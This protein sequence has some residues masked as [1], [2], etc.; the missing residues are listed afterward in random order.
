M[1]FRHECAAKQIRTVCLSTMTEPRWLRALIWNLVCPAGPFDL[2]LVPSGTEGYA[3]LARR[4]RVVVVE[5]V[6]TPLADLS[7]VIRSKRA[8]N[9]PKDLEVLPALEEA[10][11]RRGDVDYQT[12]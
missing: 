3:D 10:L 8:A 7:D 5:G 4:A 9:R 2:S 6:Q 1:S 12:H 11:R